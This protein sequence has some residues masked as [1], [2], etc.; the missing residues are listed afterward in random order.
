MSAGKLR[1]AEQQKIEI[2]R[3]LSRDAQL[4]VMDEPSAAL[5]GQETSQLHEIIRGLVASGKTILLISHFLNEVLKLADTVTVLRDGK[6]VKT[7]EA[8]TETE[9]SLIEAMLGRPL[10]ATRNAS[11]ITRG[12]SRMSLTR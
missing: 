6:V 1:T 4:I 9:G 8:A 2:L 10:V 12:S 11:L 7:A 5:G 3:A